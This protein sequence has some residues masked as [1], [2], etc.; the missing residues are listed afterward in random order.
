MSTDEAASINAHFAAKL[1]QALSQPPRAPA[2]ETSC[3][4]C[5]AKIRGYGNSAAPVMPH[6]TACDECNFAIVIPQRMRCAK[7]ARAEPHDE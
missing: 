6:G 2:I 5:R 1:T 4:L 3:S 7:R